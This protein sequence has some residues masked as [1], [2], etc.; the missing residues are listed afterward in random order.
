M[1]QTLR[2]HVVAGVVVGGNSSPDLTNGVVG[3]LPGLF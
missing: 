3:L 1:Q 2:P